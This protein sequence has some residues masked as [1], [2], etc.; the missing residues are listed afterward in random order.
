MGYQ[1]RSYDPKSIDICQ[2]RF[3]TLVNPQAQSLGGIELY[4]LVELCCRTHC[5]VFY[6]VAGRCAA[7]AKPVCIPSERQE[8]FT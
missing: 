6:C 8:D 2:I 1:T 5:R 7:V 4:I 3:S